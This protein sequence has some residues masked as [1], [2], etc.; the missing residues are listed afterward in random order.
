MVCFIQTVLSGEISM[1][2]SVNLFF[3]KL[4]VRVEKNQ[5][6]QN[7]EIMVNIT[8]IRQLYLLLRSAWILYNMHLSTVNHMSKTQIKH[9]SYNLQWQ[10]IC[11]ENFQ[12]SHMWH[13]CIKLWVQCFHIESLKVTDIH[14]ACNINS[15]V[16]LE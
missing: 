9:K 15:G 12:T 10:T 11:S 1:F 8:K 4:T 14:M 13:A 6:K 16:I 3:G 2:I 7:V 5:C